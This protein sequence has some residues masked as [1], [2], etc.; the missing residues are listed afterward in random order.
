MRI[1]FFT[2]L[3]ISFSLS[4]SVDAKLES[5]KKELNKEGRNYEKYTEKINDIADSIIK[6]NKNIEN[7]NNKIKSIDKILS[8]NR[9]S[10]ELKKKELKKIQKKE[11]ELV[12][13][14]KDIEQKLITLIAKDLSISIVLNSKSASSTMDL[15]KEEIFFVIGNITRKE[16]Q[17][18]KQSLSKTQSKLEAK[19]D[20]ILKIKKY[21]DSLDNKKLRQMTLIKSKEN[22]I[23]KSNKR[24]EKYKKRLVSIIAKQNSIK[25]IIEQLVFQKDNAQIKSSNRAIEDDLKLDVRRI[26]TSYQKIKT[27][28]YVGK[29]TIAP[30]NNFKITQ[31]FGTYF[32]PIYKIKIF[33]EA[34]I[35][36]SR[37]LHA[38]VKSVLD[39]K[40]VFMG[41]NPLLGKVLIIEHQA[42]M[43]TIYGY[44]S[45]FAPNIKVGSRVKRGTII[46]RVYDELSFE[47]TKKNYHINPLELIRA[48]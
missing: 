29:K 9:V 48:K 26:G 14:K 8:K 4:A 6:Y 34:V 42:K 41:E 40:I 16:I 27:I 44:L 38:K 47:V 2:L 35:L 37:Y 25:K 17:N 20:A 18:L 13:T 36:K 12:E 39:G 31:K 33:N 23:K 43:H 1:F 30:I 22:L 45:Q 19:R 24:K 21:I 7:Y 10:Y 11:D 32:D 3:V 46:G 5:K 15:I 28:R